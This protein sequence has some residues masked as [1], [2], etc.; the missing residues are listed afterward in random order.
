MNLQQ[1]ILILKARYK[2]VLY[3]F[4]ATVI[5]TLIVSL[6]L[7]KQYSATA[8][9]LVDMKTPDPIGGVA[10]SAQ[11]LPGYM[12]TQIDIINSQKVALKVVKILKMAES[13]AALEQWV[14]ATD[15]K[16]RIDV[17][18]ADAIQR[19][20]DVKPSRESNVI[21]LNY[22]AADPKFSAVVANAFA[23]A[24]IE[25]N[26]ELKVE[27]ARQY[28]GWF[29][30]RTRQL[31]DSLEKAQEKLSAYQREHG[32]VATEEHLDIENAR[33]AQLSVQKTEIQALK[34][35]SQSRQF[36]AR[37]GTDSMPEAL[38]SGLIQSL[39]ADLARLEAKLHETR[40]QLGRNH[41]QIQ[42]MEIEAQSLRSKIEA[43]TKQI[44]GGI[45]TSNRVNAQ[46]ESE[47]NA[48]LATQKAKVLELKK[49]RDEMSVLQREV[50]SAQRTYELVTQRLAQSNLE[51]QSTQTNIALLNPAVEPLK[52]SSPRIF[53]NV[54]VSFFIGAMLGLG[55]A[56]VLELADQ[57]IR[58]LDDLT[59][60]LGLP[61]LGVIEKL[62]TPFKWPTKKEAMQVWMQIWGKFLRALPFRRKH[63]VSVS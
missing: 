3:V 28:A 22:T 52:Y 51:S 11:M 60:G 24:Y 32:I 37:R 20:L 59:Q 63:A 6:L 34:S 38:Q 48:S 4:L 47:I 61:V 7:P 14:E 31:R 57:R 18:L 56:L 12:A 26:L 30:D 16:G 49:Q 55:A 29:D 41:P 46:R 35:E 1:F 42:Q 21:Q 43:E 17:W 58:G 25:T 50:E 54:L 45:S 10:L 33:L 15:G 5:T 40:S 19:N 8:T 27:P 39:K 23:Q 13:P 62:R 53:L 9:V 36:Q 2:V 44:V